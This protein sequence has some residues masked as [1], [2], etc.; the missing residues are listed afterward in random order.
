MRVPKKVFVLLFLFTLFLSGCKSKDTVFH[1]VLFYSPYCSHCALVRS[2]VIE[3]MQ[4]E[5]KDQFAI[6][7]IDTST[8][9][10]GQLFDAALDYY[11]VAPE[12][13]GVPMLIIDDTVIV[14]SR[15]IPDKLPPLVSRALADNGQDWPDFPP[16]QEYMEGLQE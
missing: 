8:E 12:R 3:P 2:D 13:R 15:E 7:E 14:G 9:A 5:Y 11:S 6:I 10:G 1:A 16:L 4:S